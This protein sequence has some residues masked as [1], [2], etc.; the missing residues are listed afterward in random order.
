MSVVFGHILWAGAP[1]VQAGSK[2]LDAK[3][4][5]ESI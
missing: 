4:I 2:V 3:V 5:A 1:D